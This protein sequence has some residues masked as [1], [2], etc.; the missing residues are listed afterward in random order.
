MLSVLCLEVEAGC[1]DRTSVN[2]GLQASASLVTCSY[3]VNWFYL[4]ISA[5][6]VCVLQSFEIRKAGGAAE[7]VIKESKALCSCK[8]A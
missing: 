8:V 4:V 3:I 6:V 1:V 7:I 2:A 5:F